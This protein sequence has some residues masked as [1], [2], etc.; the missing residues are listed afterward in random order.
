MATEIKIHRGNQIGGCITEIWTEKTRILIDFGE[1]LPGSKSPERFDLDWGASTGKRKEKPAVSAVFFTHYHGDHVGRF[2]EAYEHAHLY[3]SEL[4]RDVLVN[5]HEYLK[6]NLPK[7]AKRKEGEEAEQLRKEA[8]KHGDALDILKE[9][10]VY[11]GKGR[12]HTFHPS[13][14]L[15]IQLEG[16]ITVTPFWVDHS[17]GDACMF[18]IETEDKRILHTGDFRGHGRHGEDGSLIYD[19]IRKLAGQK[20]I[21]VLITEGTMMSR[22]DEKPYSE[23]D[24]LKTATQFFR[25]RRNQHAF[26]IISSTNLDSI[27]TFYQAAQ[28]N[29]IPMYCHNLYVETQIRTLGKYAHNLWKM[30]DMS[31]VQQVKLWD[32]EQLERMRKDGFVTIIKANKVCEEL[33]RQFQNCHPVIVYSMWPGYYLRKLDLALCR[34]V[35]VCKEKGIPVYPLTDGSYGSLHTSGHASTDLIAEV[36]KAAN[37]GEI[38]PI[39]TEDMG[40]F[41]DLKIPDELKTR[42]NI[43]GYRWVNDRRA[44]STEEAL[45]KFREKKEKDGVERGSHRTFVEL[46]KDKPP[47]ELVFCFRGNSQ[48]SAIIYYKNHAAFHIT[49]SGNVEFN[50]NHARYLE[51]WREYRDRLKAEEY[52][53]VFKNEEP[54][55]NSIGYISMPAQQARALTVDQLD[56]LYTDI[57]KPII[58][59]FF[60]AGTEQKRDY[61]RSK[62]G[63]VPAASR[64]LTEKV[65]QQLLFQ[66]C[67]ALKSGYFFYD[68]EFSQPYSKELGCRNQPDIL[69]IRF[70]GDGNPKSLALVEVK[71]KKDALYGKSGVKPHVWGMERYPDWLLPV[72]SSDACEI[73]N[74][75][76]DIGLITG[77]SEHF[78]K[79]RFARLPKEVLLVFT[80]ADTIEALKTVREDGKEQETIHQFLSDQGYRLEP[81][82]LPRPDGV[83]EMAVYRKDFGQRGA[84]AK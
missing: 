23:E 46:V 71:S 18:L 35:D 58:E 61:F 10:G 67:K 59:S 38:R 42:L 8:E 39:H 32:S 20:Q 9:T 80:G 19:E 63:E 69:G 41:L 53:Y 1:E 73:L 78:D 45:A 79:E 84:P 47:G 21:N 3:M 13:E 54:E 28:A 2:M 64:T 81:G 70:D 24:L 25:N 68:L 15:P 75:Y 6:E 33:V 44:L 27:S 29:D 55:N 5:I 74:Q 43:N 56:T 52:K 14:K 17:A 37:P 51:N 66:A 60:E 49:A 36:I 40:A 7:L 12:I 48:N 76:M 16:G 31:D 30:P 50:F 65:V 11:Q 57:I 4:S 26:L 34:F 22:Q 83:E 72:R 62:D 77:R 82:I